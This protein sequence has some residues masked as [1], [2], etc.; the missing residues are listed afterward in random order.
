MN[1][2]IRDPRAHELA[3]RLAAKR[4]ISMTEAVIEALQ[5]EL[6][7]EDVGTPLAERLAALA[8]D[9]MAKAGKG[10]GRDMSKDEIDEMWGHP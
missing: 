4:K 3:R 9:L 7:R 8:D 1:L 5:A 10:G 6:K 2:Q